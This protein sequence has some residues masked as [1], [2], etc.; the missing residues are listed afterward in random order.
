MTIAT[1][2]R[3][4]SPTQIGRLCPENRPG[5]PVSPTSIVRWIVEGVR[6]RGGG[7]LKLPAT[8]YPGGWRI[9]EDDFAEFIAKLTADR[10]RG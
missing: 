8:R 2:S 4:L 9:A 3:G 6:L 10:V 7:R 1:K 5:V